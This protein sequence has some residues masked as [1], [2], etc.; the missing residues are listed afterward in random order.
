MNL[1]LSIMSEKAFYGPWRGIAAMRLARS[2]MRSLRSGLLQALRGYRAIDRLGV[3]FG[4]RAFD[5]DDFCKILVIL[6]MIF[7]SICRL[8][9]RVRIY[10][11]TSIILHV[12]VVV[13]LANGIVG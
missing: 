12:R 11:Q 2:C 6:S 10:F 1:C 8:I 5:S 7:N 13:S 9:I 3:S 4:N